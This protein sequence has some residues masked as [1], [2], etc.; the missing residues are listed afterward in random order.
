MA[1]RRNERDSKVG[2]LRDQALQEPDGLA[3]MAKKYLEWMEVTH[4][5]DQT[6]RTR[7]THLGHFVSW[8]ADRGLRRPAEITKPIIERYQRYLFHYRTERHSKPLS[9]RSQR[10]YL[11]SVQMYFK[12]LSR[13][14]HILYNPASEID[15]PWL[16]FRILPHVLSASEAETILN[17]PAVKDPLG[18]R[19]RAI[20]ETFYSTGIRR[21]ELIRLSIYDLDPE[22]GTLTIRQGKGRKDR[23]VPIGERAIQWIQKYLF[24]V[25]PKLAVPPDN[26]TLFLM[27]HGEPFTRNRISQSVRNYVDGSGCGK[28]GACHLFRHTMATLMLE[29]GADL[30]VIQEILG[31]ANLAT[32]QIYTQVSIRRLKEVHNLTH[33]ANLSK[34]ESV[35][36]ELE[37]ELTDELAEG[38]DSE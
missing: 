19:D 30:R 28:K 33:P 15:L 18:L 38:D 8:C 29:N 13:G 17:L 20:L 34:A 5:S 7:S 14:N 32:T 10:M 35:R 2:I 3:G 12:W 6:V 16:G 26:G 21:L 27:N 1:K 11:M 23:V 22:L 37:S 36:R 4:Y 9:V 24:E 31:H 25:R